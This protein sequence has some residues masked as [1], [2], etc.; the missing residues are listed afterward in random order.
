MCVLQNTKLCINLFQ[1]VFTS[2][3]YCTVIFNKGHIASTLSVRTYATQ[4]NTYKFISSSIKDQ[5]HLLL[6]GVWP[7][8]SEL[9]VLGKGPQELQIRVPMVREI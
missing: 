6:T 9:F 5:I 7:L 8:I 1:Q 4:V 3:V 2:S